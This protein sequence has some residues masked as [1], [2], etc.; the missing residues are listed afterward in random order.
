GVVMLLFIIGLE[1][2]PQRL[3]VMR[4]QVFGLGGLQVVGTTAVFGLIGWSLGFNPA[5][6]GIAGLGLALSSTA[7]VLPILGESGEISAAHG[8][9]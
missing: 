7:F 4:R 2:K 1:L 8:R 3:W 5:A 6:A 9:S